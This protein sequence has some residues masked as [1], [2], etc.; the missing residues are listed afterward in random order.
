MMSDRVKRLV[1]TSVEDCKT[2]LPF[3]NS[4]K[5]LNQALKLS[6]KSGKKTMARNIEARIRQL[7]RE[8]T[9]GKA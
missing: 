5:V 8:R 4:R 9:K 7:N 1:C 6:Q 2:S 3:E